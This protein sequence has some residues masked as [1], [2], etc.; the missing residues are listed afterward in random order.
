MMNERVKELE[1]QLINLTF[2]NELL[3]DKLGVRSEDIQRFARERLDDLDS[4]DKNTD[5]YY[6]LIGYAYKENSRKL[7]KKIL[8]SL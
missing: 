8:I 2:L 3:I 6:F 5:L 7:F 1:L 4:N